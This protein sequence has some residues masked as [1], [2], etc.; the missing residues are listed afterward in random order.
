MHRGTIVDAA[1]IEA[2]TSTKNASKQR[3]SEMHQVK[4]GSEWHFGERMHIGVDC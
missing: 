4:K 1:I 3:D 2:P